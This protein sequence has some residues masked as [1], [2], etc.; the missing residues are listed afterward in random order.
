MSRFPILL[1]ALAWGA[2]GACSNECDKLHTRLE[3]CGYGAFMG[4]QAK[5]VSACKKNKKDFAPMLKC[6][7]RSD[8]QDFRECVESAGATFSSD[9][10]EPLAKG[11]VLGRT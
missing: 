7:D 10:K 4:G 1:L 6:V 8:C 3:A 9:K 5:F 11:D 2:L